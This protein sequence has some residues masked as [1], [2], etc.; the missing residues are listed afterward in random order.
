[1]AGTA[2]QHWEGSEGTSRHRAETRAEGEH[3]PSRLKE[4]PPPSP[5]KTQSQEQVPPGTK[6]LP[7]SAEPLLCPALTLTQICVPALDGFAEGQLAPLHLQQQWN[8]LSRAWLIL[9]QL[10]VAERLSVHGHP[11]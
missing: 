7:S 10:Q 1:M 6:S 5:H 4:L 8:L 11:M 3:G 9:Q 2:E